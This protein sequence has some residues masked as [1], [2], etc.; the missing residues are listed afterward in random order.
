MKAFHLISAADLSS[1]LGP[2]LF[3]NEHVSALLGHS[4]GK[5]S[6]TYMVYD[7]E[8]EKKAMLLAWE[9]ELFKI[10]KRASI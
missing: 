1:Q 3:S 8:K 5:L 2:L 7:Y 10:G 6:R 4:F 9:K